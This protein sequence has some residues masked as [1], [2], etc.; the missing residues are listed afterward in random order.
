MLTSNPQVSECLT[1][2]ALKLFCSHSR[3]IKEL[4][5]ALYQGWDENDSQAQF[6]QVSQSVENL[7]YFSYMYMYI[8]IENLSFAGIH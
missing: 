3:H 6:I 2:L 4:C 7:L 5:I 1:N 8:S